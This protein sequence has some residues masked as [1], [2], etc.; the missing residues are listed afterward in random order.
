MWDKAFQLMDK[1]WFGTIIAILGVGIAIYFYFKTRVVVSISSQMRGIRL[2]GSQ[3]V[4]I[5]P[6]LTVLY[7]DQ[8]VPR[9]ARSE[10]VIWND[11]NSTI[12]GGD[13][14]QSDSLRLEFGTDVQIL[15]ASVVRATRQVNDVTVVVP[16][17]QRNAALISFDFLDKGDGM[18]IVL[19]HTAKKL[20]PTIKGTI[21]GL[22]KGVVDRGPLVQARRNTKPVRTGR[23]LLDVRN[24]A[25]YM[26]F[27]RTWVPV[28]YGVVGLVVI[29]MGLLPDMFLK[30]LPSLGDTS[31]SRALLTSGKV[32]WPPVIAGLGSLFPAFVL[33]FPVRN[34]YPSSLRQD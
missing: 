34:R 7:H 29:L 16:Q 4:A 17:E 32:N 10:V 1:A 30:I 24:Q 12:K 26:T 31:T 13:I 21:R 8:K 2:I 23:F 11:G 20:V 28:I 18:R 9:L 27:G 3:A 22:P 5:S 6:A 15:E 19:L 33:G 14:V 25:W